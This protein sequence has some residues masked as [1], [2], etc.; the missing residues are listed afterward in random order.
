[1]FPH[2]LKFISLSSCM[3]DVD[4]RV[5]DTYFPGVSAKVETTV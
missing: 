3:D 4:V 5:V 2:W 1:M